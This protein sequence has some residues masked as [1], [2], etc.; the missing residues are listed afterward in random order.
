MEEA[1]QNVQGRM[2]SEADLLR[3]VIELAHIFG[4]KV[5]HTRPA[6]LGNGQWRTAI[7]GDAGGPDLTLARHGVF[8]LAELKSEHGKLSPEQQEWQ[9]AGV[10]LWRPGDWLSGNIE[11]ILR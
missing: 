6:R 4:W 5:Q 10:L 7:Q 9:E 3:S 2:I 1:R 11:K 8:I